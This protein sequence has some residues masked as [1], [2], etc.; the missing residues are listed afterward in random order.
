MAQDTLTLSTWSRYK[1]TPVYLDADGIIRFALWVPPAEF[2][3]SGTNVL[4]HRVAANEVGFLDIIAVIYYGL[5]Y[6]Q[7]YWA[8]QVANAIINPENEMYPGQTLVIPPQSSAQ[9]FIAR[10]GA[11]QN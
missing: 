6:E 3:A 10:L 8:I 5:G 1:D 7:L 2:I 11:V 9:A 4:T